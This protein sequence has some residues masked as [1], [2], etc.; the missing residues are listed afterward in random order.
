MSSREQDFAHIKAAVEPQLMLSVS[1]AL[2]A[3]GD[4]LVMLRKLPSHSVSLILTDPPYHATKKANIHS[5]VARI[6]E[7]FTT[8]L[9]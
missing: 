8:T 1:H 3:E 2:V 6:P 4:S 9:Q 7:S 5:R